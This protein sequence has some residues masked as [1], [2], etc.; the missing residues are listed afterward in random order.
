ME[1]PERSKQ[2]KPERMIMDVRSEGGHAWQ[3]RLQRTK[4]NKSWKQVKEEESGN[5]GATTEKAEKCT[6]QQRGRGG[7]GSGKN[8]MV[9]QMRSSNCVITIKYYQIMRGVGR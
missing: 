1:L 8:D 3:R 6:R 2:G 5:T 4:E 9:C 7:S